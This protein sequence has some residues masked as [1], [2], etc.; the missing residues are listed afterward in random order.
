MLAPDIVDLLGLDT[1]PLE[2]A[3]RVALDGRLLFE[4]GPGERV[5]WEAT[6]RKIDE[7]QRGRT[8]LPSTEPPAL[9]VRSPG[10]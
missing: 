7:L 5:H 6:T 9:T 3:G 1:A 8:D 2:L 10:R 4:P